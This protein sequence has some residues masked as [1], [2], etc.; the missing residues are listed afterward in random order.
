ML[1]RDTDRVALNYQMAAKRT[2]SIADNF[3]GE[4]A[5]THVTSVHENITKPLQLVA[6]Y[7]VIAALNERDMWTSYLTSSRARSCEVRVTFASR[8]RSRW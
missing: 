1:L 4:V 8:N 2:C 6:S 5:R 7:R 3:Y